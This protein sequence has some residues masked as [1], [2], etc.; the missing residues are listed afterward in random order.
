MRHGPDPDPHSIVL[1]G[2]SVQCGSYVLRVRVHEA[3]EVVFGRFRKGE[4]VPIPVGEY[5]YVGSALATRGPSCLARRLVRHATRTP[6]RPPHPIREAMLTTFPRAALGDNNLLPKTDKHL[7][8]N[9]DHLLNV[10][11]AELTRVIAIR[12]ARR[13]ERIIAVMLAADSHTSILR[14]RLGAN[15]MTDTTH[16]LRMDADDVWWRNFTDRLTE[17]VVAN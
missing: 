16:L 14:E 11:S 6:G 1:I 5:A 7:H 4:S 3:C 12:S 9:V 8:W 13:L 10:E 17:L 2:D 15:D